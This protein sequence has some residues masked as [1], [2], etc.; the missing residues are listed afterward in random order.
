MC[1]TA[2]GAPLGVA[3]HYH[4]ISLHSP[5]RSAPAGAL[6]ETPHRHQRSGRAAR[7]TCFRLRRA[8]RP[9]TATGQ[10]GIAAKGG[11]GPG[12]HPVRRASWLGESGSGGRGGGPCRSA[13]CPHS[14]W[15]EARRLCFACV[16]WEEAAAGDMRRRLLH[17]EAARDTGARCAGSTGAW[18]QRGGFGKPGAAP[19]LRPLPFLLWPVGSGL[20]WLCA[21]PLRSPWTVM[22]R[23]DGSGALRWWIHGRQPPEARMVVGCRAEAAGLDELSVSWWGCA[24]RGGD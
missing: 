2:T 20:C 13:A 21:V 1:E 18:G 11:Q 22:R 3:N 24:R 19:R 15:S 4:L 6:L 14:Q 9:T 7:T 23:S 10:E 5:H 12:G 8:A 16:G 17:V